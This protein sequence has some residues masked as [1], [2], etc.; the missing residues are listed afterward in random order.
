MEE[1]PD[2]LSEMKHN[3]VLDAA[4]IKV[5]PKLMSQLK[6]FSTLFSLLITAA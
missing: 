4:P 1:I 6:D 5:T 3:Y 2:L